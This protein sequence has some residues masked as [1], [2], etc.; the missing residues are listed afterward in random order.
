MGCNLEQRLIKPLLAACILPLLILTL[1]GCEEVTGHPRCDE[2]MAPPVLEI[3]DWGWTVNCKPNF[4]ST[5][6]YGVIHLAWTDPARKTVF[7][8][9]DLMSDKLLF[10]VLW[11][12]AGHVNYNERHISHSRPEWWADAFAWCHMTASQRLGVGFLTPIPTS[13]SGF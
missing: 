9:P 13:C 3:I 1:S 8:W 5:D 7:A 10:K 6:Q 2:D 12:E 11:H 4:S